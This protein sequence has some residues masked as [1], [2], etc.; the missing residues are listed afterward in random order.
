M[1]EHFLPEALTALAAKGGLAT[2]QL[3]SRLLQ[4]AIT[5]TRKVA[6]DDKDRDYTYVTPHS[7]ARNEIAQYGVYEALIIAVRDA[8]LITCQRNPPLTG[9]VIAHHYS[10]RPKIFKR[11]ALYVLSKNTDAAPKIADE[12]LTDSDLIGQSWCEDEYAELALAYFSR[13]PTIRQE[14]IFA[15]IDAMPD[16]YRDRWK[17]NLAA[18]ENRVPTADD[19]RRF[20]IAVVREAM[21]KWRGALPADRKQ[22]LDESVVELGNPDAW[23]ERLFPPEFSPL[24][25]VDFS[26]RPMDEIVMLLRSWKPSDEPVRQTI[27]ALGEELRKAVE[28]EPARFAES[29]NQFADIRPIYIRRLLEGFDTKVRNNKDLTWITFWT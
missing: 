14:K 22:L 19:E 4:R 15:T 28:Q 1:Y 17:E 20:N 5:I 29:A 13:L 10:C 18:A 2:V 26:S 11:I 24:S 3:F 6:G 25:S 23:H 9:Q 27:T 12:R 8:A 7:L 21:W 16:R